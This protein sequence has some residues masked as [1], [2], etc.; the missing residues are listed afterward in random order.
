MARCHSRQEEAGDNSTIAIGDMHSKGYNCLEL[1]L[2]AVYVLYSLRLGLRGCRVMLQ[3][4]QFH[5]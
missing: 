5:E 2:L 1:V 3:T 4:K